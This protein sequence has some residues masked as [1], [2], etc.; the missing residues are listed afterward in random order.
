MSSTSKG[1]S[2]LDPQAAV[3]FVVLGLV[4]GSAAAV[5]VAL[6]VGNWWEG[7]GHDVPANPM[8]VLIQ[9]LTGDIAWPRAATMFLAAAV[10]ALL[11]L[12]S[13]VLWLVLRGRGKRS[14]VD[15]AARHMGRGRDVEALGERAATATAQRL[16]V[17]APGLPIAASVATGQT[18]YASW[19][20]VS[21][22]IW[23]PRT[24]KTTSRAIPAILTAP[25]AVLATSNKRDLADATRDLRAGVGP[26]WVFDPQGIVEEPATWWWNPL[27]YVTDEVKASVLA[28]LFASASREPG[29]RTDAFFDPAGTDLLAGMLLAAALDERPITQVYLWL[30][31]PTEDEAVALLIRYGHP[32]IAANVNAV[33]SS[34]EKQR[35]GVYGTAKQRV[36]FLTNRQ[37]VHW[38]VPDGP[39][40]RRRQFSPSD[41]VRSRSTLYSLSR[42]GNG[43]AGPLVTA[44]TVAVCEAAEDLAKRSAGGRLPVPMVAVL[45]EAANVCRWRTLPD[46]YS[47]YGSRG[48]CLMT[49]LQSW[50]QGV[51]VWGREGMRKLWSAA[52]V[53]VYGGGVSEVEF[54]QEVSQLVGDFDV[55]QV[56]TSYGKGGRSTS[57][58]TRRERILDVADLGSLPK[59]RAVV[60]ASGSRPTLARTIPWMAGPHAEQVA[61]SI[62][63]HDPGA[64][65]TLS[66]AYESLHQVQQREEHGVAA[67]EVP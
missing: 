47:H 24:G 28:D 4:L 60:L 55:T 31:D 53:K 34:P 45:D 33:I 38:V 64:H 49:I 56:S 7:N 39:T 32:L 61:A 40:D 48:I 67:Q 26:V 17:N 6:R 46:I 41:F 11:L 19:E 10:L 18:L 43:S 63:A 13:L 37:A 65:D 58:S 27:S 16:G 2:S 14:R 5:N 30:T 59:G 21:V 1:Q 8:T 52:N 20:D 62:Q 15:R 44:L 36:S 50:S 22:D 66:Q 25:G 12:G 35:A 51:E 54:L 23:G 57:R 3:L 42:E 9:V 29:S